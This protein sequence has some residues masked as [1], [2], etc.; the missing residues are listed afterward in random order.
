M[1]TLQENSGAVTVSFHWRRNQQSTTEESRSAERFAH[2]LQILVDLIS[3]ATWGV[4]GDANTICKTSIEILA[5]AIV[6]SNGKLG[7]GANCIASSECSSGICLPPAS[8]GVCA[9]HQKEYSDNCSS[10]G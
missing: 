8:L 6:P 4:E 1:P 5:E 9:D 3:R 10:I 7:A 2:S